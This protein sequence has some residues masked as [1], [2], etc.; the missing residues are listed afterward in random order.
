MFHETWK[1]Y[2]I[3]IMSKNKFLLE[4]FHTH[5][6]THCPWLLSLYKDDIE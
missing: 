1:I 3:Q 6:F 2:E 4:H 5:L